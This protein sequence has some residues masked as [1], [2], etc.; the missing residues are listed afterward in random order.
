MSFNSLIHE[1]KKIVDDA[2]KLYQPYKVCLMLSGGDDS[3]LT[4]EVCKA[5]GIHIDYIIHGRT[6]TGLPETTEFVRQLANNSGIEYLE[7][8]AGNAYTEYV[9]RKGFFGKGIDAHTFSYHVLKAA[10]FR[11]IVSAHIRQRK[12]NRKVLLLNGVRVDETENRADKLGDNVY[13]CDPA[14]KSNIWVNVVH[15]WT[16]EERDT[17][18]KYYNIERNPV[19][20]ALGRS[21]ECMCGTMQNAVARQK[22]AAFN[23][24]WGNWLDNLEREV[25]R[26]HGYGWGQSCSKKKGNTDTFQPM[27]TGC[28]S[29]SLKQ[30]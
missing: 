4:Y 28:K 12:R 15:W 11:K 18:L 13:N 9:L 21:G 1:S 2:L 29:L 14:A 25:I 6:G 3:L 24:E 7:A 5:A 19:S 26:L 27:C 10:P 20:I 17:F 22:A 8:D 30:S 23:P 16:T